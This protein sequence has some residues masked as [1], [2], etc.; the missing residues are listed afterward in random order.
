MVAAP[1]LLILAEECGAVEKRNQIDICY[2]V[3]AV[4]VACIFPSADIC[5]RQI[6]IGREDG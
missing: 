1:I 4:W 5:L 2:I 3:A 6:R